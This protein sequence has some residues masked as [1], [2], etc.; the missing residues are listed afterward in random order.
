M[1][2]RSTCNAARV[3]VRRGET[4]SEGINMSMWQSMVDGLREANDEETSVQPITA[5]ELRECA[6]LEAKGLFRKRTT[7]RWSFTN[8][9]LR[10]AL[11]ELDQ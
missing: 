4:M 5:E 9:G 6:T 2:K 3:D 10:K 11:A 8:A 7:H 1:A